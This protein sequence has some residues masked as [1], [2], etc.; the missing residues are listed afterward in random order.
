MEVTLH[1][2]LD[3]EVT[4]ANLTLAVDAL[5]HDDDWSVKNIQIQRIDNVS[6]LANESR[7]V[8]ISTLAFLLLHFSLDFFFC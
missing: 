5:G 4:L 8:S 3:A 6:L 7:V 2:P 1:N